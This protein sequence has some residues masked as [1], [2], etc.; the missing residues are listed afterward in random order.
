MGIRS[1]A[2][3]ETQML[4]EWLTQNAKAADAKTHVFVGKQ[5][6]I[7]RDMPLTPAQRRAFEVWSDWAD[8]RIAWPGEVWLVEAKII[9]T[10]GAYGQ[11]LDYARQYRESA[12][13]Q[14]YLGKQI[15]PVVLC[16]FERPETARY[17]AGFGVRTIVFTP[18][19]AGKT[20]ATKIMGSA[21]DL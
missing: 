19:W 8:A 15:L 1:N 18:T 7:Y 13:Y 3:G 16:A 21:L 5:T 17:F 12:D 11:V 6:L 14:S 9:G 20:L 10:S 2:Q 4:A